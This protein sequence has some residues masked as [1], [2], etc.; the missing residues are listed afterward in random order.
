MPPGLRN[1]RSVSWNVELDREVTSALLVRGAYQQRST[2]RDFVLNPYDT[3]GILSLSNR[4][5]SI[6]HELQVSARYKL[7]RATVNASYVRSKAYGNLN[8]FNQFFGNNGAPVIEPDASARLPFDA[9]NRFL[10]W[11]EWSAPFKLM[12]LPVLDVHTG[13]PWSPMNEAREYVGPRNVDRFPRFTSFD[14][15]VMRPVSLRFRHERL[16]ARAG[17]A[18][19]NLFN[20]FNPRDVQADVDS[21]RYGSLFNGVG[22][23][24]RGKFIR[25]F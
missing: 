12:L 25:D 4:G 15:Q 3:L 17:F 23:T 24:F 21:V 10:A 9:P 20:Q 8:D 7:R 1:P 18:V 2:T 16:K 13:F 5:A 11:G 14:L 19:Y 6:Y 22:R